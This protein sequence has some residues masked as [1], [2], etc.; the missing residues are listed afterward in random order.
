MTALFVQ[1]RWI[2]PI[3]KEESVTPAYSNP[4][5]PRESEHM[6]GKIV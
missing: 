3:W 1:K 6:K 5:A 4:S 2:E